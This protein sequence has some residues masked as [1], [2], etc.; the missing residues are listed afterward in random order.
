MSFKHFV[1]VFYSQLSTR[2]STPSSCSRTSF[3]NTFC[4]PK[5]ALVSVAYW[6]CRSMRAKA[7]GGR[8]N[9]TSRV[10]SRQV[11]RAGR[12]RTRRRRITGP[13]RS[14]RGG[15][16]TR[17][18]RRR[19]GRATTRRR[20][21]P[22]RP[23]R[24]T[25]TAA[26]TTRR[27]TTRVATRTRHRTSRR[28]PRCTRRCRRRWAAR[29]PRPPPPR[30]PRRT[31]PPRPTRSRPEAF[32]SRGSTTTERRQAAFPPFYYLCKYWF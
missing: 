29:P 2:T 26:P 7:S 3:G 27:S 30:P 12:T 17:P 28:G 14:R 22:P 32:P 23:T 18:W 15:R 9:C 24:P 16:C 1:F 6:E 21:A 8:S 11:R 10:I 13:R 25:W 4:H 20:A 31:P 5:S 19:T